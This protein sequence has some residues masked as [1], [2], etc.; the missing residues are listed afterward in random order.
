[1]TTHTINVTINPVNDKAPVLDL[2]GNVTMGVDYNV[3]YKEEAGPVRLS[4]GLIIR[5]AD[6]QR[7]AHTMNESVVSISNG[8]RKFLII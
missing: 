1:M 5:D 2:N 8:K 7:T 3:T 4:S 6:S